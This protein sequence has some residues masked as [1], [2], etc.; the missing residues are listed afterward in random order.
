[1][2]RQKQLCLASSTKSVVEVEVVCLGVEAIPGACSS[3]SRSCALKLPQLAQ[4]LRAS[5]AADMQGECIATQQEAIGAVSMELFN[6]A[7]GF[8]KHGHDFFK[9]EGAQS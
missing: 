4:N 5:I 9:E 1:M 7:S 3:L 6:A 8:Q 2:P